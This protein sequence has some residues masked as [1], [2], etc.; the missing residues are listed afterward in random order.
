MRIEKSVTSLSWIPSEAIGGMPK[1]PFELGVTHYDD[2][3]PDTI[4]DLDELISADAVREANELRAFI[5]VESGQIK[6]SGYLGGGHLGVTRVKLGAKEISFP[7]VALPTL[8]ADPEIGRDFVRFQQTAGGRTALPAPR[9][10]SHKPFVQISSA[11]AWTTLA[12]KI[13]ADGRSEFELVG[14]SPFPRHW[15]Y[16]DSGKL[17]EKTG[18]VDF[19]TW[20]REA[21]GAHTP[22]GDQDSPALT[23]EVE[24]ALE[25]E[26]SSS[27]MRSGTKPKIQKLKEGATLTEQG[28]TGRDLF[29][30]LDGVLK[31]EVDGEELTEVGPGAILGE[32]AVLEGG[33]RT[34]TLRAATPAKV[35]LF[36]MDDVAPEALEKLATGHRREETT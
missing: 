22:W 13:Y 4:E 11:I 3:P 28:K 36:D 7:A 16:D 8:Q 19:K 2:P 10:V 29:L 27:I 17:A 23:T 26:L 15:I 20:Y 31:V 18:L 30:L 9:R 14:A 5:E 32:R 1:V 24:S 35:A 12:L 34:S 25:R 6:D 21:F 33:T